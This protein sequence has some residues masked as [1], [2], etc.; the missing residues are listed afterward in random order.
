MRRFPSMRPTPILVRSPSVS[1]HVLYLK[2]SSAVLEMEVLPAY[3]VMRPVK[4]TL[5]VMGSAIRA[6]LKLAL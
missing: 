3:I 2:S 6:E 5:A 1:L 4:A